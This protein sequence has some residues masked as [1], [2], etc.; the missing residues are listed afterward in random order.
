MYMYI[1]QKKQMSEWKYMYCTCMYKLIREYCSTLYI[2]IAM[3]YI[4]TIILYNYIHAL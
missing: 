2:G 1:A 4:G 3:A